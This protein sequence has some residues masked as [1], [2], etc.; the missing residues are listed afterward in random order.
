[1]TAQEE[2]VGNLQFDSASVLGM[3][4]D[5]V[6][7]RGRRLREA[8]ERAGFDRPKDVIDR[9]SKLGVKSS[10]YQHEKGSVPFSFKY[11]QLYGKIFGVSPEWL[12]S[13][14]GRDLTGDGRPAP[15]AG[16]LELATHTLPLIGEAQAGAW[17]EIAAID[18]TEAER[19][20]VPPEHRIPGARQYWIRVVGDSVDEFMREGSLALCTDVWDWARDSEDLFRRGKNKLVVCQRE[21]H[22][23]YETTIKQLRVEN[24]R[25][26]L[27]PASRNPRHEGPV[28]LSDTADVNGVAVVA[29]VTHALVQF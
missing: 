29:V 12:Y 26:E 14:R 3:S 20:P 10:Y 24:G 8:R 17:K 22:G 28:P 19:I 11:A 25:P 23:L 18:E 16:P 21:R 15:G 6:L 4:D 5:E 9:F 7:E 13:G 27:W 1:M 2:F